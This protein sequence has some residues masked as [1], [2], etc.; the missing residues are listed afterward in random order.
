MPDVNV[1]LASNQQAIQWTLE[2][3]HRLPK[4]FFSVTLLL[5][6]VHE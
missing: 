2:V 3:F 4:V 1:D 6:G 5:L